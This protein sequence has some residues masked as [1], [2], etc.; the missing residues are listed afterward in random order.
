[1][2]SIEEDGVWFLPNNPENKVYGRLTFSTDE[3]PKLYL[4]GQL[5][6]VQFGDSIPHTLDFDIINGDLVNNQKVT[7]CHCYQPIGFKTGIQT[8]KVYAK[9]LL[10]GHHFKTL[11]EILLKGVVLRYKNL[12]EWVNL[13]NFDINWSTNEEKNQVK[14]INVKQKTLEPIELGNLLGFLITLHDKPVN[15][16]SL[17]LASVFGIIGRKM[18]LEERKSI[19]IRAHD[20]EKSLDDIIKVIYLFQDLLIFASGQMTYPYDIQSSILVMEKE[21]KI[22]DHLSFDLMRGRIKPERV[23]KSDL[24]FEIRTFGEEI[25]AV[26]EEKEKLVPIE[27]YFQLGELHRLDAKFDTQQVLFSFKDVKEKFNELLSLWESNSNNLEAII[28]LYLRLTYIP[29]RHIN[30]FFLSLAQATEAFHS[31]AYDGKHLNKKVYKSVI[32][33]RLEE[34]VASIPDTTISENGEETD[35]REYKIILKE[36]K[37]AHLNS[38]SLRERL[39]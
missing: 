18:S 31:F 32:R 7:L 29:R 24:G 37:L 27:I 2:K 12:E 10:V 38:Y 25:K 3:P 20:D 22:P 17:E 19:I 28:D 34:A 13:P 1:M 14:E 39:E 5:Q 9:Y 33:K 16:Q 23:A 30:D 35:L 21:M 36:E 4:I 11:E 8:S 26:E 15:L 6:E